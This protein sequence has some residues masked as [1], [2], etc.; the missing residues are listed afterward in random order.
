[1]I[2]E[3]LQSAV[4]T[5][6]VL[7][8]INNETDTTVYSLDKMLK[9]LSECNPNCIEMM[10]LRD[11]DYLLISPE[12]QELLTN[13]DL[14]L[15]QHCIKTFGGYANQQLYR[16]QQKTLVALTPEE[17]NSHIAKTI[18]NMSDH[19]KRSWG[20][21]GIRV[22]EFG[23]KLMVDSNEM[24]DIPIEAFYGITNEIGNV[25][26]EYNKESKRNNKAIEHSKI[27]KHAMHLLRLYMMCCDI[28]ECGEIITYRVDEHDLLM[29]IRNGKFSGE[30]GL[31]NKDFFDL[32]RKYEERF[33]KAK[34]NTK[35]PEHPDYDAIKQLQSHSNLKTCFGL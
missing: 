12:G 27:N 10:G 7:D 20:I 22:K 1:M 11:E 23:G 24:K 14:F 33:E 17:F 3:V 34:I 26:K 9:L 28:L 32:L 29:D 6:Y 8:M 19:L 30:D 13:K 16:L 4:N 31:P 15:S 18:N 21:D 25:V 35:L 2:F 5:K